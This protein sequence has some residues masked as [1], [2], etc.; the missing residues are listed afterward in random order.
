MKSILGINFYRAEVLCKCVF[1]AYL[2]KAV[3]GCTFQCSSGNNI[4][5]FNLR[6]SFVII[7]QDG[8]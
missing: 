2:Q 4:N 3:S 7:K 6:I 1:L 8:V 5:L